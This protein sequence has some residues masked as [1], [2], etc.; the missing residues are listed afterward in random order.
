MP[1]GAAANP[2]R[3][4]LG[5]GFA[6]LHPH[7]RHAH[8]APLVAAGTLDVEHGAH[9]STP[10]LVRSL[11][12]PPRGT[13]PVRLE[14]VDAGH[15]LR[16]S[17]RIGTTAL[18]T[19]QRADGRLLIERHGL[20]HITFRLDV[21][22]GALHYTQDGFFVAGLRVPRPVSPWVCADVTATPEGWR[23]DVTVTWRARLVCRYAGDIHSL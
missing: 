11:S 3:S 19:L 1:L 6:S 5:D 21:R 16:W 18:E 17:R 14:I 12:L 7:V 2:Y 22:N 23:V 4:I 13:Q 8:S 10:L 20:G 9:W 15:D